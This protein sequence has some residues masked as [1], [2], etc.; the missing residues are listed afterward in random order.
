MES[1][2]KELIIAGI[3][4]GI[5]SLAVSM[6]AKRLLWRRRWGKGHGRG[7]AQI[8]KMQSDKLPA[9]IGPYCFGKMA[10]MPNGSIYAWSSGQLGLKQDGNLAEGEDNV[11]AQAEQVLT[12]L[13]NLAADNGMDLETHCIK[14]VVYLVDM[15]DFAKVNEVYKRYFPNEFPARTC[16]AI[17]A[18]P[19]GGLVEIES[20][21]FK[22]AEP[23]CH[24]KKKTE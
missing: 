13:K 11:V 8:L 21:F 4:G 20:V 10:Q 18:L 9:P 1:N 17:K 24:G 23:R 6:F 22:P 3:I 12:N 16:I 14:N 19:K 2:K 5:T 7:G 15:A